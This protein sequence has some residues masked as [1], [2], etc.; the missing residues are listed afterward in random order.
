M[1][2]VNKISGSGRIVRLISVLSGS[3]RILKISIWYIPND[4]DDSKE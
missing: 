1:Q 4:D 3:G 2:Q